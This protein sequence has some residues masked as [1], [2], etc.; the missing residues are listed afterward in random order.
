MNNR[1]NKWIALL[2]SLLFQSVGM[3]YVARLGWALIY[4]F[5]IAAA[6]FIQ[7]FY[8]R[9]FPLLEWLSLIILV[10]C[11]VHTFRLASLYPNNGIRPWYSRWYG[12]FLIAISL[13][14]S[15]F[16]FRSFVIEPFQFRSDSMLPTIKTD[17]LLLVNKWG[18]GHYGTYGI[19]LF[20]RP[21]SS[22]L[23]RGDIIVFDDPVNLKKQYA[24]RLMGLPGDKILYRNQTLLINGVEVMRR[25]VKN[26]IDTAV[27]KNIPQFVEYLDGNE[28]LVIFDPSNLF[29]PSIGLQFSTK[30]NCFVYSDGIACTVPFNYYFVL[31]DNRGKS[32]YGATWGLVPSTHILGKVSHIIR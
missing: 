16:C 23:V 13:C 10:I 17:N 20:N 8:V 11:A 29:F 19:T 21:I 15:I 5:L 27:D 31:D 32:E 12:F 1:P 2:L 18:Y 9:Q 14:L 4:F 28:Y 6:G 26:Y 30:N 3:L 24:K 7:F 25:Q 22:P